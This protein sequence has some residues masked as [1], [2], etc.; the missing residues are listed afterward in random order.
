MSSIDW[1]MFRQFARP[2]EPANENF[3]AIVAQGYTNTVLAETVRRLSRRSAEF[4]PICTALEGW[5]TERRPLHE[6]WHPSISKLGRRIFEERGDPRC[7]LL[8]RLLLDLA[9]TLPDFTYSFENTGGYPI[10][11]QGRLW[12]AH[13][14][15][16]LAQKDNALD[17]AG[18]GTATGSSVTSISGIRIIQTDQT[19]GALCQDGQP[20]I[21]LDIQKT[22]AHGWDATLREGFD[23]LSQVAGYYEAWVTRILKSIILI[24]Q[25]PN[26]TMSGSWADTSGVVYLSEPHSPLEACEVLIHECSH[27]YFH[28]VERVASMQNP[29]ENSRYFSPPVGRDRPLD[30]I[31]IAYHAFSNVL[32][33]Y[34]RAFDMG[35]GNAATGNRYFGFAEEVAVLEEHLVASDG[36]SDLGRTIFENLLAERRQAGPLALSDAL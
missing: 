23:L 14:P 26:Q 9:P 27:Q 30:M 21:P 5:M 17:S 34:E 12:P 10:L 22:G 31:L 1:S 29:G 25:L 16:S 20:A 32:T 6:V 4:E 18:L 24:R 7:E 15:I 19:A 33:F 36:L 35:L 11:Y 2:A 28:M 13:G 3:F 8:G